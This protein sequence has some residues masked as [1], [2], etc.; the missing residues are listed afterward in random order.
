MGAGVSWQSSWEGQGICH[1]HPGG[2][3]LWSQ[4]EGHTEVFLASEVQ[5][6]VGWPSRAMESLGPL[7]TQSEGKGRCGVCPV[8]GGSRRGIPNA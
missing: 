4:T 2:A 5:T 8:K 7:E 6:F 1:H 3:P